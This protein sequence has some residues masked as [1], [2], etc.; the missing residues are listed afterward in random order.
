MHRARP[1]HRIQRTN[2][3]ETQPIQAS[4]KYSNDKMKI[5]PHQ[6]RNSIIITSRNKIYRHTDEITDGEMVAFSGNWI[7]TANSI[8]VRLRISLIFCNN[9]IWTQLDFGCAHQRTSHWTT[10]EKCI[11]TASEILFSHLSTDQMRISGEYWPMADNV[12]SCICSCI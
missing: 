10:F 8:V 5:H 4:E 7:A 9:F 1:N 11:F 12:C 6:T 2:V 3:D